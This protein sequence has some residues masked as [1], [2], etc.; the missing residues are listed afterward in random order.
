MKKLITLFVLTLVALTANAQSTLK[1][2]VNGD[3]EVNVT[4]VTMIVEYVMGQHN[5]SFIVA[6]ADVNGDGSITVTDV[7]EAVNTILDGNGGN[8]PQFYLT[9]PDS[10]HPH[11]IDLGL[12]SGMKWACCNVGATKPEEYGGYYAWGEVQEKNYYDWTTYI[13]CDGSWNTCYYLGS[14]ITGTQ[15][16]VAHYRWGGSW[17]MPSREQQDELRNNCTYTWTTLNGVNGG[18]FTGSNGGTIFLPA[19]GCR[20]DES[21]IYA[22]EVGNYWSST[23]H[24]SYSEIAYSLSFYSYSAYWRAGSDGRL[25]GLSV[26]PVSR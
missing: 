22:G 6:N 4:D 10:N 9:C 11:L 25:Y 5:S 2:D 18:Q 13:H 1:G 7:A 26:R 23:Q 24:A 3:G 20:R 14:D 19:A 21:L 17:V 8:T 16:D 15:Y 12:P